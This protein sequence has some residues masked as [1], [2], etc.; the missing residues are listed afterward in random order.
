MFA[1]IFRENNK[2]IG[3]LK[4]GPIRWRH[5]VSDLVTVIG[6]RQYWGKGLA[7]EA[8]RLGTRIAFDIYDMRKLSAGIYSDNFASIK[9]YQKA[10]WIVEAVLQGDFNLNGKIL[11]RVCV[12]CF[13][14][15]HF[16][17]SHIKKLEL[18]NR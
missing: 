13:N 17:L 16:D 1:I 6:D 15:K 7:T 11:D 5:K 8:I 3:N 2:H 4:I 14:P 9:C 18:Q 10:G 12:S